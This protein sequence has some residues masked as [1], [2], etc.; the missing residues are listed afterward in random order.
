MELAFVASLIAS[1]LIQA[2]S[3]QVQA[4]KTVQG[5]RPVAVCAAPKG[6]L[7]A[8]SLEDRTVCIFDASNRNLIRKFEGHPQPAYAVAYSPNGKLLASGDESGRI[9]IWDVS[10]NK[11]LAE[12]R[13]HTRGV[14][15]VSFSRDSK[16]IMSTGKDDFIYV[17]EVSTKKK[18]KA[19]PGN[20]ANWFSA[21]FLPHVEGYSVG[22]LGSGATI[23]AGANAIKLSGVHEGN[24]VFDVDVSGV[25]SR[26]VTAGRDGNAAIWDAKSGK[27]IQLLRGHSDWVVRSRFSPSGK[28]VAT[29]SSDRTVRVWDLKSFTAVKT[30]SDQSAVGAPICF[31]AD[32]KF[33]ITATLDDFLQIHSVTPPAIK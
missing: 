32:G 29:S 17:H 13:P 15:E 25:S 11:K 7:F 26:A 18:L 8:A 21:R 19:L 5:V 2:P 4:V 16:R 12:I 24:S 28:L 10:A 20:G 33:L 23:Y 14:Q 1:T 9:M 6:S 31:T 30:I 3:V 27:K 22:T